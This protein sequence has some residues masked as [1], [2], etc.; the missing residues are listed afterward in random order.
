MLVVNRFKKI[1]FTAALLLLAVFFVT[2]DVD[3]AGMSVGNNNLNLAAGE[4]I[5][6]GL[7][8][9]ANTNGNFLLLEKG[10]GNAVF[11]IDY[12][13]NITTNGSVLGT[14][15]S[16]WNASGNNLFASSTAYNVAIGLTN[17]GAYKLNVNG[18]TNIT[19]ALNV[20]G[21]ITGG[22]AYTGTI[23]APNVSSGAFGSNTGGGNY[24]FPGNVGIGTTG[25]GSKLDIVKTGNT[26]NQFRT[27]DSEGVTPAVRTYST[28]DGSG[29]ILNQYYAGTGYYERYADFVASM[30]D[31][32][33]TVMRFFTKAQ[34]TNPVEA[35]RINS[36]GNVGIGT[37]APRARLDVG[38]NDGIF[39]SI[40]SSNNI[41]IS[42]FRDVAQS[43]TVTVSGGTLVNSG[44]TAKNSIGYWDI[45]SYPMSITINT[46]G[47]WSYGGISFMAA[48]VHNYP[49]GGGN[50]LPASFL[51]E[52]SSDCVTYSTVDDV[53]N[54]TSPLYYKSGDGAARCYRITA[55]SAQSG[56]PSS[57]IANI[58][59][60]DSYSSGK[61]PF[62]I[63]PEGNAV[64][65]GNVGIGVTDPG[66]YKLNVNGNTN[67]TGS[68]TAT[69]FSGSLSGTLSSANVSSGAFG[70]NTGGGNYSFPGNV[71][72]GTT[73]PNGKLHVEKVS[74]GN[75]APATSGTA[76]TSGL[77]R[78]MVGDGALDMGQYANGNSWIQNVVPSNLA[79]FRNIVIQPNGGN[80]GIG[81]TAPGQKLE[82]AGNTYI[83][84]GMLMLPGS[85]SGN[86]GG[87]IGFGN[88]ATLKWMSFP[89][90]SHELAFTAITNGAKFGWD[91]ADNQLVLK[92]N[93]NV[94]IRLSNPVAPLEINDSTWSSA[95]TIPTVL[96]LG[97][98]TD[99]INE[100]PFIDFTSR[101]SGGY[102]NWIVGRIGGV[103]DN[104]ASDGGALVFYT[105]YGSGDALTKEQVRI[106]AN[107]NVGIN[108]T[109]P[110]TAKLVITPSG[111]YSIDAGGG[112]IGPIT[113][114]LDTDA[115]SVAY[116]KAVVA[117]T[118]TIPT[119]GYWTA[120]G[121]NINNAN[122]GNV[123]V[124]TNP[125][126]SKLQVSGDISTNIGYRIS[127]SA[128]DIGAAN[129]SYINSGDNRFIMSGYYGH[130][131]IT[132]SGTG[133]YILGA[134]G[135]V[136]IGIADPGVYKLNVNGNTNITGTLTATTF[137]GAL[138]GTVSSGNVSAGTFGSNTGGGNYHFP[139]NVYTDAN[140]G[141]GLVG[142]YDSTKYQGIFS[143]GSSWALAADGSGP[144][145]LYGLAWTHSN[146]GG[147]SKAG[148]SHQLL[149]MENGVTKVA[150]GSGIW[151]S[152]DVSANNYLVTAADGN[153]IKFWGSDSYKISMGVG[154]L[155]QY[156]PVT[157][158]SIKTQ[159]NSGSTGRGFTWGRDGIAPIAAIDSTS[160]NMQIAGTMTAASF[161]GPMS[162][163]LSSA[164]VSAGTFGSNTGG[165]TYAFGGT[166]TNG[167]SH[168]QWD[169][170]T[171]YPPGSYSPLLDIR[172]DNATTG[173][174]GF[175][176]A[177]TLY[178]N[179]GAQNTTVGLDFAVP[180]GAGGTGNS[181]ALGG[182]MA[183]KESV[184]TVGGWSQGGLNFYV[185]NYGSRVDA[186]YINN[187]GNVGIGST[188]PTNRLHVLG[189][190]NDTISSSN[191]NVK[192][193][194]SGGNGL[195]FGTIASSPYTS[196]IQS[197]YVTNFG[198]A[199]YPLSLNPNG[200]NVGIGTTGPGE[201]LQ[202]AGAI[203]TTGA[204]ASW[205]ANSVALTQESFGSALI[206]AGPDVSTRGT[207][208]LRIGGSTGGSQLDALVIDNLGNVGINTTD[209]G[210]YKLNVNGNT[211]ITGT[212]TATTFSG[213]MSGTLNA[214]NVSSGA[215]GSNTSGGNYSFPGNLTV[216]STLGAGYYT[217]PLVATPN[218]GASA[219]AGG[220]DAAAAYDR[221]TY[222][223][224]YGVAV[225][226]SVENQWWQGALTIGAANRGLQI[227][228]GYEAQSVWFRRGSGG[229]STWSRMLNN[230][231]D[232]YAG[233]MNQYVRTT[234][235]PTFA[236]GTFNGGVNIVGNLIMSGTAN[237]TGINKITVNTVDPLYNI[238]GTNY[239]S[240][241]PSV[242]GGVKEEVV[243]KINLDTKVGNEYQ[244]IINFDTQT[245]GSDLWVWHNVI[246]FNKDN[247]EAVI[248]PY[249]GFANT[250][251]YI[252][253]NSLIFKS[254]RP[255]EISY[256]LLA[257]RFDWQKWPTLAVDQTE[258]AGLIIK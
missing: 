26:G 80:V 229:W 18:D 107:G 114:S 146:A 243:G 131:F 138:S 181:V 167:I 76:Q 187:G 28:A 63:S 74:V 7:T 252:N 149:V 201:K 41:E 47:W 255:V 232:I 22:G 203:K 204:L 219:P 51:V 164:N 197:G 241:A 245:K 113:S 217:G 118:S 66:V 130:S 157:D 116:V 200:G 119:V 218:G 183:V 188:N 225:P 193:E 8:S 152:G 202:V 103:Y 220:L 24:S 85:S 145:N 168:Y 58:Q 139:G 20:T 14:N 173:I 161:S 199:V 67:I 239:S 11:K 177:L 17:P 10:A 40:V 180:E 42:G 83:T 9:G 6:Y 148:L 236:G 156:G 49:A 86:W 54:Y 61:G 44:P 155:Y 194:G 244:A 206:A 120:S 249:G 117:G 231:V 36:S 38:T 109:N 185:K 238:F 73:G 123:G 5:Y 127:P 226:A 115:A 227:A 248:T 90:L 19:G 159:M 84:S 101:W 15:T 223:D 178:N 191:L 133:L 33:A 234:D 110:T 182:I 82:V 105:N 246:D 190:S 165:G 136:G 93:G 91:S 171:Y 126:Y 78:L 13:G 30:S 228:G 45:T 52:E 3:A 144:G 62:T 184:G 137:S 128:E 31:P 134:T 169:G 256:R 2:K 4:N 162:G 88:S 147:Q 176:P 121:T 212:L 57:K 96:K 254:D 205:L 72:I 150:L 55:R 224:G 12:A 35:L 122:S 37:T 48:N 97:S 160:G 207:L 214:A 75:E 99:N 196:Y 124:G 166:T 92:D 135:N 56:E 141:Y 98:Y 151:T 89:N 50:K 27:F 43:A 106:N 240:F 25:S 258:P 189:S 216:S 125:L 153:G 158:Y 154:G 210:V 68:V 94:G 53:T 64:F 172:Q 247:V 250:Y 29:L 251:Y 39:P 257:K 221:I 1:L 102:Q 69:S 129:L 132:R 77:L 59:I 79:L 32:S 16:Y 179:D 23:N 208:R 60:F 215:F 34:S 111:T 174:N 46:R 81:T 95:S 237:V 222:F 100:G 170:A 233:N 143:M 195:G 112:R 108:N 104:S 230:T 211:N 142:V 192:F 87:Q 235:A 175:K 140:Y 209:P 65:L 71:G 198:T 163:T 21:T 213:S 253:G 70:S 186:M 242:V